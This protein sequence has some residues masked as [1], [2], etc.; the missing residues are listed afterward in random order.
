MNL[1]IN[2]GLLPLLM[3][4]IIYIMLAILA[5]MVYKRTN[6]KKD[7]YLS[8][9][10][11]V[12]TVFSLIIFGSIHEPKLSF[13]GVPYHIASIC[14]IFHIA[15]TTYFTKKH[16]K[17]EIS[18]YT[19]ITI[20][21]LVSLSI[22][23][24]FAGIIVMTTFL[25]AGIWMTYR[26]IRYYEDNILRGIALIALGLFDFVGQ[27]F[28]FE[29]GIFLYGVLVITAILI[30]A[31]Y[32]FLRLVNM[33]RSAGINSIIDPETKLYNKSF[34]I[35]KS[36]NLLSKQAIDILYIDVDNV[37]ILFDV[38]DPESREQLLYKIGAAFKE[39]IAENGFACRYEGTKMV[40]IILGNNAEQIAEHF[41]ERIQQEASVNISYGVA[42]STE[43]G[44]AENI[45]MSLIKI[46]NER[47][48]IYKKDKEN[49]VI[50]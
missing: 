40:G 8:I 16:S 12:L 28:P 43:V 21:L 10:Y 39:E 37:E 26:G 6:I 2:I 9:A 36:E 46:A 23:M 14:L 38:K 29:S 31:Y 7:M 35:K 44:D 33:I 25:A 15:V 19:I 1:L 47:M 48:H 20:L 34:L 11:I 13:W 18:L 45:V 41:L 4:P 17:L 24:L 49:K 22:D 42:S 5:F 50:G 30:E 3:I 32:Y 27:W